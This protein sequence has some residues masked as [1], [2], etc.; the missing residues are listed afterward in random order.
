MQNYTT[1]CKEM[2]T[3]EKEVC[4]INQIL[5]PRV[6]EQCKNATSQFSLKYETQNKWSELWY[7]VIFHVIFKIKFYNG[8]NLEFIG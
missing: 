8:I 4:S 1:K 3:K 6:R 2:T 5:N 7:F